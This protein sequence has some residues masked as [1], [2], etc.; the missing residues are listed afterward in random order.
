MRVPPFCF[1]DASLVSAY[2]GMRAPPE[3]RTCSAYTTC[4]SAVFISWVWLVRGRDSLIFR[5]FWLRTKHCFFQWTQGPFLGIHKPQRTSHMM[6][7]HPPL[8]ITYIKPTRFIRKSWTQSYCHRHSHGL[9]LHSF[10]PYD[11]T[12]NPTCLL[13]LQRKERPFSYIYHELPT[14]PPLLC[15]IHLTSPSQPVLSLDYDVQIQ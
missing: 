12:I 10:R 3:P 4:R 6:D 9:D 15:T 2:T 7:R 1:V 14:T 11:Q 8:E 5:V 13:T